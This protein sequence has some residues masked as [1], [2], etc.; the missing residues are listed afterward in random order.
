MSPY[1]AQRNSRRL[2]SFDEEDPESWS[3]PAIKKEDEL[4]SSNH[5]PTPPKR[6]DIEDCIAEMSARRFRQL[7]R[8][9]DLNG[10]SLVF[11][12]PPPRPE[13]D[14]DEQLGFVVNTHYGKPFRIDSETIRSFNS[15]Y[16]N[17][18]FNLSY[19]EAVRKKRGLSLDQLPPGI[20][21]ILDLTPRTEG[22]E[23]VSY[24]MELSC[25][26]G[27]RL[28]GM[29][30]GRW[31]VAPG[32]AGGLDEFTEFSDKETVEPAKHKGNE[33]PNPWLV[34][35]RRLIDALTDSQLPAQSAVQ[36]ASSAY[37]IPL[38]YTA[39]RHR[40]SIER[41]FLA[42]LNK[43][44]K[45]D[46]APKVYSAVMVAKGLEIN[47]N[48][49]QDY[50]VRWLRA[51]PNT[52]FLEALPEVSLKIADGL[53]CE[54]ICKDAFALLVGEAALEAVVR[55]RHCAWMQNGHTV[56]GRKYEDLHESWHTRLEYA[57][58]SLV[59]RVKGCFQDLVGE[60][61]SWVEE[62][63]EWREL[64]P[65]PKCA[66]TFPQA[67]KELLDTLKDF[68]R[69]SI[70][71]ILCAEY[72]NLD[73]PHLIDRPGGDKLFPRR[74]L[75]TTWDRLKHKE[76]IFTRTFWDA[77]SHIQ[78]PKW[79]SAAL[80]SNL[81]VNT[82]LP[83]CRFFTCSASPESKE[84]RS[85]GVYKI[86][87]L[88]E[89]QK[90]SQLCRKAAKP[91][92][93]EPYLAKKFSLLSAQAK[94]IVDISNKRRRYEDD[95][96]NI[97][98]LPI[99]TAHGEKS[100]VNTRDSEGLQFHTT[101]SLNQASGSTHVPAKNDDSSKLVLPKDGLF[102]EEPL[103][104]Y[105]QH[106]EANHVTSEDYPRPPQDD[107]AA[108][109]V[110][111]LLADAEQYLSRIANT[112]HAAPQGGELGDTI[113]ANLS[114]VLL[115]LDDSETKYLPLWAGGFDDG[116]AGV[117]GELIPPPMESFT[118]PSIGRPGSSSSASSDFDMLDDDS[119]VG[120]ST[121]V[122]DGFSDTVDRRRVIAVDDIDSQ[123]WSDVAS[124]TGAAPS[125]VARGGGD[126]YSQDGL[127]DYD[128][129]T[130]TGRENAA[131]LDMDH[132]H[133][134]L[135]KQEEEDEAVASAS[136]EES[137]DD[138][139]DDDEDEDEDSN[140]LD[141]SDCDDESDEAIV[142]E[143]SYHGFDAGEQDV[144]AVTSTTKLP[145]AASSSSSSNGTGSEN[146]DL[147]AGGGA[148]KSK[149][150]VHNGGIGDEI[151]SSDANAWILYKESRDGEDEDLYGL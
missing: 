29:S 73:N 138:I 80:S 8:F 1:S 57:R 123:T 53:K 144:V 47:T 6:R 12:D 116:T 128:V 101:N 46:S 69:G 63:P 108:P 55:G 135:P 74:K 110:F 62:L 119:T 14:W 27:V 136:V 142:M 75:K 143:E 113:D 134:N 104:A 132:L 105:R 133:D 130:P 44:P 5:P 10:D 88:T 40:A 54:S 67:R 129:T 118:G 140:A 81:N 60:K 122:N 19:Q 32:L 15:P 64:E 100:D 83:R 24:L 98:A 30:I 34:E 97:T 65:L 25:P 23:A 4:E 102:D 145:N 148:E 125:T 127:S 99:R 71:H 50:V 22:E 131:A 111:S 124:N 52:R 7:P 17:R 120:T 146:H 96:G 89:L 77:L 42:A 114:D 126:E 51:E 92:G 76:R 91:H 31:N 59:D 45:L 106:S 117:F 16:L 93:W 43:D 151:K 70:Y 58:N 49:L 149:S 139:F 147:A 68:I 87:L 37:E 2:S 35:T 94:D 28:W 41:I 121:I 78:F 103:P 66:A 20:K 11:I 90:R 61:M 9:S 72:D 137:Y 36:K 3:E 18:R 21:Y 26:I 141:L 150:V 79:D 109:S 48:P 13:H 82:T 86:V 56:H 84:L 33:L 115:C 95:S 39:L 38:D 112:M 107:W 85:C